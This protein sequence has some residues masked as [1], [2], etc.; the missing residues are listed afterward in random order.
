MSVNDSGWRKTTFWCYRWASV[1]ADL[2][3]KFLKWLAEME[4]VQA[5]E[6]PKV[7]GLSAESCFPALL[8]QPDGVEGKKE[9]V[10]DFLAEL[11]E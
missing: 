5:E 11:M 2:V 9:A 8:Q 10:T 7:D 4:A 6:K 1:H 3:T